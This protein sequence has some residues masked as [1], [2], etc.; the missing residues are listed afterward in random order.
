MTTDRPYHRALT[1]EEATSEVRAG[2][3]S[4]FAP[5]VVEAFFRCLS[6]R[7]AE[8]GVDGEGAIARAS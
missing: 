5:A 3:G 2:V 4:Q 1:V 7:P 8:L 6:R